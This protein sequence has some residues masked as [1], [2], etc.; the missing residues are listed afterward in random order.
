MLSYH[1][2]GLG[3]RLVCFGNA[4]SSLAMTETATLPDEELATSAALRSLGIA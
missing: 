2:F 1:A 3:R 4:R